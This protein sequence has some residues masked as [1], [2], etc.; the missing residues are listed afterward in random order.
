VALEAVFRTCVIGSDCM[1]KHDIGS[2][3]RFLNE[4]IGRQS[5]TR[6][7]W[8][9]VKREKQRRILRDDSL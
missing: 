5:C 3:L 2:D 1:M 7:C 9:K 8:E 4:F 6:N